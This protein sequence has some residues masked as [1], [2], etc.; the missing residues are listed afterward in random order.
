MD[1]KDVF[2]SGFG[3][4]EQVAENASGALARRLQASPPPGF[5]IQGECLP[6]AFDR[7]AVAL[8]KAL[9]GSKPRLLMG[10]GQTPGSHFR[11]ELRARACGS[12][13]SRVDV[14]GVSAAASGWGQAAGP[15]PDLWTRLE[16]QLL[17]FVRF[18]PAW[19]CSAGAGGY[20]CERV[21]RWLLEAGERRGIPALFVHVPPLSSLGLEAQA[22]E[23]TRL[24]LGLQL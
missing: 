9:E 1:P 12:E 2:L 7:A 11:M 23:L 8:D 22:Q 16:P 17:R 14:D 20:V 4:F 15:G 21:Y 24:L 18:E 5:R 3:P 13:A 10:L 6:V 19:M